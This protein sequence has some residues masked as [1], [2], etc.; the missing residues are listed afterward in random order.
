M[1]TR[2]SFPAGR[3]PMIFRPEIKIS[4]LGSCCGGARMGVG[5]GAAFAS[6]GSAVTTGLTTGAGAGAVVGFATTLAGA[7]GDDGQNA[8]VP[9]STTIA[10]KRPTIKIQ[11]GPIPRC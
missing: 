2:L 4:I 7:D 6:T 8:M 3:T 5:S 9:K 11:P 10:P 1:K